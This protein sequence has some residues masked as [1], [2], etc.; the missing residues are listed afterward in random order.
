MRP[1]ITANALSAAVKLIAI[2][3]GSDGYDRIWAPLSR[4][5]WSCRHI[6]FFGKVFIVSQFSVRSVRAAMRSFSSAVNGTSTSEY[7]SIFQVPNTN[8]AATAP[9]IARNIAIFHCLTEPSAKPVCTGYFSFK[10]CRQGAH[11]RRRRSKNGW[12]GNFHLYLNKRVK[13]YARDVVNTAVDRP[14]RWS[15]YLLC[16]LKGNQ[17]PSGE[18]RF[19]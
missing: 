11:L 8:G 3:F 1:K 19:Q 4:F 10:A 5:S 17:V 6:K 9:T 7:G 14:S 12:L 13:D 2:Y 16:P 15:W 18:C